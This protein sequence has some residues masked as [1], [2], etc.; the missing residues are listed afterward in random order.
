MIVVLGAGGLLGRHFVDRARAAG[1]EVRALDRAACDIGD[2]P[3]VE[4][5]LEG[6]KVVLNCAAFTN[7]DRAEAEP[8]AA[9]RANA[10]GP[11]HVGRAA[12][13]RGLRA[14]HISTDFVFGGRKPTPYD[15]LDRP[16]PQSTYARSK[17]GGE[18]LFQAACPTGLTVRVQGLYGRGGGNFASKLPELLQAKK[19]LKLDAERRVQPTWAGAAAM[20]LLHLVEAE[21][22]RRATGLVHLS[23]S[24]E[25]TWAAFARRMAER[26]NVP[27]SFTEV[28]TAALAA[29]APRPPNCLFEHRMLI[30]RGLY[31][32][33]SW[34]D[35][36]D[37]FLADVV[38]K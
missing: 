28:P 32:M 35:A 36:Q 19:G 21:A 1:H 10:L 14:I 33:P 30:L 4:R 31:R 20:Q 26:M 5:A 29:P 6:G 2:A 16:D 12:A 18:V 11:E 24:G 3:Q 23:C 9:W 34:Q 13:A 15:E 22:G 27:A 37:A 7:V 38:G 8:D 25:T 17:Y